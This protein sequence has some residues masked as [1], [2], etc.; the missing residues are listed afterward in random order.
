MKDE[1]PSRATAA[2]SAGCWLP[3]ACAAAT[4]F[5]PHCALRCVPAERS[6]SPSSCLSTRWDGGACARSRRCCRWPRCVCCRCRC[7]P[8]DAVLPCL[9]P[10]ACTVGDG[11]AQGEDA[12]AHARA[13]GPGLCGAC[14]MWRLLPLTSALVVPRLTSALLLLWRCPCWPAAPI[15][16]ARQLHL[17]AV[18]PPAVPTRPPC[19]AA[20]LPQITSRYGTE[21]NKAAV[22]FTVYGPEGNQVHHEEGVSETEIAGERRGQGLQGVGGTPE[23]GQRRPQPARAAPPALP[24]DQPSRPHPRALPQ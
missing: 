4:Q 12:G 23:T 21:A 20:T 19:A 14:M 24:A 1:R 15:A 17:P 13:G 7:T 8:A 2:T 10:C 16:T 22:D 3:R 11:E 6:A 9:P 18:F 5:K